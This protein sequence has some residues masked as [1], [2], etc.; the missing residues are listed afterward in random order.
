MFWSYLVCIVILSIRNVLSSS[1]RYSSIGAPKCCLWVDKLSK[2]VIILSALSSPVW[3]HSF[4]LLI[5]SFH[6]C[7]LAAGSCIYWWALGSSCCCNIWSMILGVRPGCLKCIKVLPDKFLFD[8]LLA[9]MKLFY[10]NIVFVKSSGRVINAD[11][12]FDWPTAAD[13]S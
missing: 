8:F 3:C 12:F 7:F 13:Y 4:C 9:D 2:V 6:P 5:S 1:K 11:D 10:A